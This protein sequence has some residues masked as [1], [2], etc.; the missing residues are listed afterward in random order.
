MPPRG[1]GPVRLRAFDPAD[2]AVVA[3]W[4]ASAAETR[5]WCSLNEVSAE[6]VAGW[7][8]R[9]DVRADGLHD[10]DGDGLVGYGELWRTTRRARSSWPG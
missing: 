8:T 5:Q 4:S 7:G 3:G 6:V 1:P 2:A 9:A 10:G